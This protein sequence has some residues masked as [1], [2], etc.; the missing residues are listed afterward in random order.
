MENTAYI[1]NLTR[2]HGQLF[3]Q[4]DAGAALI[5]ARVFVVAPLSIGTSAISIMHAEQKQE[6][7][8]IDAIDALDEEN[9]TILQSEINRKYFLPNILRINAMS[10]YLGNYYWDVITD[11][12]AKKFLL[13]SPV[14]NIR[15]LSEKRVLLTDSDG[16]HYQ[17]ADIEQL[18]E[19]SR[20]LLNDSI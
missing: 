7:I 14:T 16:I 11:R 12:G 19:I 4:A 10:I 2:Q 15:L 17:I 20:N 13:K 6:L 3:Y 18:D 9:R 8:F 1:F 5:P